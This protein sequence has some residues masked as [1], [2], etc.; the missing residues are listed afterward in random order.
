[1]PLHKKRPGG[2]GRAVTCDSISSNAPHELPRGIKSTNVDIAKWNVWIGLDF[3]ALLTKYTTPYM[4]IKF[5][6]FLKRIFF[7][8][9]S[10][11]MP[12]PL[13][14]KNLWT[15]EGRGRG[16][17]FINVKENGTPLPG[18]PGP[19]GRK[20]ENKFKLEIIAAAIVRVSTVYSSSL[21]YASA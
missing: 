6:F 2:L 19:D 20:G 8:Y 11:R 7:T 12:F 5:F 15:G 3:S 13:T 17:D 1:M 16:R 10:N 21:L 18:G 9:P 4:P 14:R